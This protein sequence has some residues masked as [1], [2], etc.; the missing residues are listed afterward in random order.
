MSTEVRTHARVSN[1]IP[2][3]STDAF[4]TSTLTR[5]RPADDGLTLNFLA[6]GSRAW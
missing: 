1:V 5:V 2:A 3:Y 4:G 6:D